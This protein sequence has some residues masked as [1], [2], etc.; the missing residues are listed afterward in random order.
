MSPSQWLCIVD[1]RMI[2][3]NWNIAA[4]AGHAEF[5]A[6]GRHFSM[7]LESNERALGKAARV[8]C[9][10]NPSDG[11]G[12][13]GRIEWLLLALLGALASRRAGIQRAA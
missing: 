1:V 12:S 9:Q 10:A 8:I 2:P 11:G 4:E 5:Q 3:P 13:G 6:F 7:E